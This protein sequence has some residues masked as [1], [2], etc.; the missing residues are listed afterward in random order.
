MGIAQDRTPIMKKVLEKQGLINGEG[1]LA[2]RELFLLQKDT[3][4]DMIHY[5]H[6]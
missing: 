6:S 3:A 4:Y 5:K 2:E 1:Y